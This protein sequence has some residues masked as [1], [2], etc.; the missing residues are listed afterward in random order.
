[1]LTYDGEMS[2]GLSK[3]DV[4]EFEIEQLTELIHGINAIGIALKE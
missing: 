1:M 3:E 4:L 2:I